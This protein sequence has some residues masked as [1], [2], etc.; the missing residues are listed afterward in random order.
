LERKNRRLAKLYKTAQR[1]V[2]N[3]SHEFRT[4]LTVI[5]EYTDILREGI[6][7]EVSREQ[8]RY[9]DVVVD[10]ADD[11]NRMVDDML[12]VSKIEAGL[13]GAWRTKC[14]VADIMEHVRPSLAKKAE[15]KNVVLE[16]AIPD[17][18]PIVYCDAEKV[19]RVVVN[20]AVNAIKFCS[21]P[22]KVQIWAKRH[23]TEK[24]VLIG[25]TDNGPGIDVNLH[26]AVFDR[27]RQLGTSSRGS[28]KGFGLGL[29]IAQELVELNFGKIGIESKHGL[30]CTFT[31]T[32]PCADP[33]EI[34]RRYVA[35]MQQRGN[36][37]VPISLVQ[38]TIDTSCPVTLADDVD[39]FLNYLLRRND[40]LFRVNSHHWLLVVPELSSE[41][42]L[43]FERISQQ[44]DETNSNRPHG[45]LPLL[46]M[47]PLGT[48][49]ADADTSLLS[50]TIRSATM[51]SE[52]THA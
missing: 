19:G 9:L 7:G 23:E 4:P 3:V 12:D 29:S 22:G 52:N 14:R 41:L 47:K 31:F 30:G 5:K 45:P 26:K 38:W 21:D 50:E 37:H 51:T 27:F 15:L 46:K 25:V 24:S 1:F 35:R 36:G 28:T 43:M 18:L 11:L 49:L 16:F 44:R 17:D 33:E 10:R 13:L 8:C 42:D 34:M 32:L 20:L 6:L 39:A 40:I 48:W 2:N